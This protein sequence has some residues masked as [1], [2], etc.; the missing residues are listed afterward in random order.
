MRTIT[1]LFI[2]VLGL[3][4][5]TSVFYA[6]QQQK[7]V[8]S[9]RSAAESLEKERTALRNQ[10]WEAERRRQELEARLR[11][12]GTTDDSTVTIQTETGEFT[13]PAGESTRPGPREQRGF[14]RALAVFDTP[15]AQ[16][17]LALQQKG[18]LDASYA[19]LF[20]RLNLTPAQLEQFKSLLV[21]K[22][23]ALADVMAAAR[24]QGMMGRENRD[25]IRA[26]VQ[27]TQAE[28]DDGIRGV[29]GESGYQ[30]YQQYERTQPQRAVTS[31]L[32]QRLS[33]TAAPLSAQQADQ[34][35]QILAANA[36]QGRQTATT[37]V[38]AI[39]LGSGLG[40]RAAFVMGG[41]TPITDQAVQ[42]AATVLNSSQLQALRD[43]QAEQQ[44]QA[45]L[46]QLMRNQF[47]QRRSGPQNG[48]TS[49]TPSASS[50]TPPKG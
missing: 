17:L 9:A 5:A 24:S 38:T 46:G 2:L 25:E 12:R 47:P 49:A 30:Q 27:E 39:N 19:D 28:I 43:L 3:T 44:A 50:A 42:Q 22:R 20:R 7:A 1:R 6:F 26:L 36:P 16:Q 15:E 23:A 35:V 29:L 14:G 8:R 13:V 45:Q 32:E 34:L 48:G 4:A 11:A 40:G 31:Q 10:L 18:E 37:A 21:E 33:Y 41:G